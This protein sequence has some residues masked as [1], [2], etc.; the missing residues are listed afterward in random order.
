MNKTA[1]EVRE[2]VIEFD[3]K[4]QEMSEKAS[5]W[6]SSLEERDIKEKQE[7]FLSRVVPP[8]GYQKKNKKRRVSSSEQTRSML[9]EGLTIREIAKI[10]N[11]KIETVVSNIEKIVEKDQ[12]FDISPLKKEI[13]SDKFK[14]IWITFKDLYGENRDLLLAP[15]KN[16]LGAGFTYEEI[17]IV[18]LFVKRGL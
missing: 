1:L 11:I 15:I 14:K 9:E 2:D 13:S 6:L 4:L 12:N 18:R 17:R 3:E 16:K 5:R 10:R 7:E 8:D